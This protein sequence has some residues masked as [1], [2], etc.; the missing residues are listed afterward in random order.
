MKNLP[1]LFF[2][3]AR[4]VS[5]TAPPGPPPTSN[6][7][8]LPRVGANLSAA[9]KYSL[10]SSAEFIAG[11]PGGNAATLNFVCARV[12]LKAKRAAV[13]GP[14]LMLSRPAARFA[15]LPNYTNLST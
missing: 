3:S 10:T 9:E 5:T 13:N 12:P 14:S 2:P 4:R 6:A 11:A 1:P 7:I 15:S 8:L